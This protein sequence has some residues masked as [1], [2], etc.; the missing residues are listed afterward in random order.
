M[1][2]PGPCS[3][4]EALVADDT[5]LIGALPRTH[6]AAIRP[7]ERHLPS[8]SLR[9]V[10]HTRPS[11]IGLHLRPRI[12]RVSL[13]AL[14]T[15]CVARM[16]LRPRVSDSRSPLTRPPILPSSIYTPWAGSERYAISGLNTIQGGTASPY[17][18]SSLPFCVR[19]NTALRSELLIAVLQHSI[20]GLGL[21]VTL[22]GAS[23]A[24]HQTISSPHGHRVATPAQDDPPRYARES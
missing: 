20:Q 5:L 19:F 7:P 2:G 6:Y 9:R 1:I 21:G 23:P 16:G 22:A 14:M 3:Y 17:L 4:R 8:L 18:S 15:R 13:V 12:L 11:M 24:R 10:R